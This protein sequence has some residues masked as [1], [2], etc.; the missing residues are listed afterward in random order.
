MSINRHL[1][2]G[3]NLEWAQTD[4]GDGTGTHTT[5]NPDGTIDT[6]R[7]LTPEEMATLFPPTPEPE[8]EPDPLQVLQ[9]QLAAQQ[10]IIEELMKK[11][12]R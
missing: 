3:G 5:Y 8:P 7:P 4:N 10:E 1:D 6:S 12:Q 11:I 9:E 2:I